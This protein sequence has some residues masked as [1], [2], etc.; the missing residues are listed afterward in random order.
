MGGA[1][2]HGQVAPEIEFEDL[3]VSE[4]R[5][6]VDEPVGADEPVGDLPGDS[7][8]ADVLTP[9]EKCRDGQDLPG[10]ELDMIDGKP[11]DVSSSVLAAPVCD[12]PGLVMAELIPLSMPLRA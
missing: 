8:T 2:I 5:V 10:M 11:T 3:D 4:R 12:S 6:D 9:I 7:A 1:E